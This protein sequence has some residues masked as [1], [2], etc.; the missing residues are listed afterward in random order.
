[1]PPLCEHRDD[2]PELVEFFLRR[3]AEK[4][5]KTIHGLSPEVHEL[6]LRYH[7]PGNVRE[8]QHAIEHAVI[9][10]DGE[11]IQPDDLPRDVYQPSPNMTIENGGLTYAEAKKNYDK[12]YFSALLHK[13]NG[14]VAEAARR[15]GIDKSNLS[16]KLRALG[17]N[18]KNF[19]K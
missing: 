15:A 3:Y 12:R 7:W 14:N 5:G 1:M 9:R 8:L 2:F 6:F 19:E 4:Y 17:I 16:K 11:I 10:T 18:A 13:T